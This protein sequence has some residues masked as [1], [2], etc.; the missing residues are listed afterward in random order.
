MRSVKA[1]SAV[2]MLAWTGCATLPAGRAESALYVDVRKAV[3]LRESAEWI[4]DRL[5]V[6]AIAE[7][8]MRSACQVDAPARERLI[9]WLDAR[10]TEA[11]GP[12]EAAYRRDRDA[13]IAEALSL[14]RVRAVV[15]YADAHAHECPFWLEADPHFDGVQ[16]DARRF[17]LLAESFGGGGL[18]LSR[19]G[20]RLG[21]GGGGRL[22]FAWGL[23]QR[24]TLGVGGEVGGIGTFGGEDTSG[25]RALVARFTAA[26]PLVL[27]VTNLSRIFD[28]EVA[29]NARWSPTDLRLPPGVRVGIGYGVSTVRV[30]PFMPTAMLYLRYEFLPASR[31]GLDPSEHLILVGTKVGV[32]FD[33]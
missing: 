26:V 21:G 13:A 12:A 11:G 18:I 15:Q 4:V 20:V 3:A 10:I 27:R 23:D 8:T 7:G 1:L 31:D 9:A 19:G 14:E 17:V 16:T 29:A 5:E 24:L 28:V 6:E 2:L 32:D 30:G 25:A 22:T 33:P